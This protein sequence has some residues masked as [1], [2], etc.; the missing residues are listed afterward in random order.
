MSR[1]TGGQHKQI[2]TYSIY[3]NSSV[4]CYNESD[5]PK[6]LAN[7]VEFEHKKNIQNDNMHHNI[8]GLTVCP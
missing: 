7:D 2:L 6:M 5:T 4:N 8:P 3:L 1:N